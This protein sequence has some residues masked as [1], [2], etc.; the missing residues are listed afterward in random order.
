MFREQD[1]LEKKV[2]ITL[3][4]PLLILYIYANAFQDLEL[5]KLSIY[6]QF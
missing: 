2:F 4:N 6:T 5:S 3:Y 1:F